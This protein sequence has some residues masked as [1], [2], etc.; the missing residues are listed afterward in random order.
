[1]KTVLISEFKA[2][3]I[4]LLHEVQET[5]EELLVTKRGRPLARILP[6]RESGK[7]PRTPGDSA[8]CARIEGD[9]VETDLS[10]EW[11]SA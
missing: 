8:E 2:G 4:G 3:C 10:A 11:E 7:T 1:V 9:I 5:K 6:A